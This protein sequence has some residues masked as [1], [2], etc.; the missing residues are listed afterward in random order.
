MT[1]MIEY[2]RLTGPLSPETLEE[3]AGLYREA[4]WIDR[5]DSTGFIAPAIEGSAAA[6]GA[7][8]GGRLIGMGRALSDGVSDAFIQDVAVKREFRKRGI[9]G[10][11]VRRLAA[12]LKERGVDWIGLV[13]EPGTESFYRNLGFEEQKNF[14][15]WKLK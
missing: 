3:L 11:I 9:G 1:D 15:L 14:T 13:G 7:F 4:G 12:L 6:V 10:E 5:E 2:R 8:S